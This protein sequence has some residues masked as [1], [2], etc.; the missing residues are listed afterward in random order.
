MTEVSMLK[1]PAS[2]A[3]PV[4]HGAIPSANKMTVAIQLPEA[5]L[6]EK[7]ST[8]F[9]MLQNWGVLPPQAKTHPRRASSDPRSKPTPTSPI[10][11]PAPQNPTAVS[12][13]PTTPKIIPIISRTQQKTLSNSAIR[14]MIPSIIDTSN[15]IAI[16]IAIQ[17]G[18]PKIVQLPP[19][20]PL[21][22]GLGLELELELELGPLT[23][24]HSF[25]VEVD[26][27]PAKSVVGSGE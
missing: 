21:P 11:R 16:V 14:R 10:G 5:K 27:E 25:V 15:P 22:P 2:P 13:T 3:T 18:S 1:Y 9:K 8:Q 24:K 12:T 23:W 17:H 20:P 7:K 19:L 26:D 6:E 4:A